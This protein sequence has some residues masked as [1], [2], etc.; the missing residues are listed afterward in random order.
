[1]TLYFRQQ[2]KLLNS[3]EV[4]DEPTDLDMPMLSPL[5]SKKE[6]TGFSLQKRSSLFKGTGIEEPDIQV[7]NALHT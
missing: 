1:M 5:N 7:G 2:F 4:K 6:S 3:L